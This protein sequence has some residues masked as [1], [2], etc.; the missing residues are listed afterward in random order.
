MDLRYLKYLFDKQRVSVCFETGTSRG[1][2]L[3]N[4]TQTITPRTP[5][6]LLSNRNGTNETVKRDHFNNFLFTAK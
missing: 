6:D 2:P 3:K 5:T 1:Q 4:L